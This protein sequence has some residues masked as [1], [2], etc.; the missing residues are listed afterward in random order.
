MAENNA[1]IQALAAAAAKRVRAGLS[2]EQLRRQAALDSTMEQHWGPL[3]AKYGNSAKDWPPQV[4]DKANKD[5]VGLRKMLEHS[6]EEGDFDALSELDER[7]QSDFDSPDFTA[8]DRADEVRMLQTIYSDPYGDSDED[9]DAFLEAKEESDLARMAN[10]PVERAPAL[11]AKPIRPVAPKPTPRPAMVPQQRYFGTENE[12]RARAIVGKMD[13]APP[14]PLNDA[15]M[16]RIAQDRRAKSWQ[17]PVP[18]PDDVNPTG[19]R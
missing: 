13:F 12:R 11:V 7:K 16:Q 1:T 10:A 2:P 18:L 8:K 9:T 17:E 15:D 6:G 5:A 19:G 14:K 4:W 3:H